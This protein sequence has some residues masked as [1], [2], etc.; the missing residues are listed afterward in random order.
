MSTDIYIYIY[1]YIS[2]TWLIFIEDGNSNSSSAGGRSV[3]LRPHQVWFTNKR[4]NSGEADAIVPESC[5]FELN[6]VC[7]QSRKR[8]FLT[9]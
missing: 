3:Y 7:R 4:L 6:Q 1:T 8:D 9:G 5:C 2:T